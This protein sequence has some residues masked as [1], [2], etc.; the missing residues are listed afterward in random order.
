[1]ERSTSSKDVPLICSFRSST[2]FC[3]DATSRFLVSMSSVDCEASLEG[4]SSASICARS[5]SRFRTSDSFSSI[6]RESF[7]AVS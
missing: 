3:N 1:M 4:E 7:L 5:P 2:A 6:S